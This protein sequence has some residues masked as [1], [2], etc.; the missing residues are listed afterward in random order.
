MTDKL[1]TS[2]DT[3]NA[4]VRTNRFALFRE[5]IAY[6][7][8]LIAMFLAF[9]TLARPTQV[10]VR[11]DDPDRP[12]YL[13][14]AGDVSVRDIDAKRFFHKIAKLLHAWDSASVMTQYQEA[15]Q[16]MTAEWALRFVNEVNATVDVPKSVHPDG[17]ASRLGSYIRAKVR[18]ETTVDWDALECRFSE[19]LWHCLGEISNTVQPLVGQPLDDP[20]L[21]KRYRITASF[22]EVRATPET[23]DSLMVAFWEAKEL[24]R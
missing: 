17:K 11:P 23:I 15:Q 13:V 22:A 1:P 2:F 16:L 5:L 7:V 12:S 9:T 20:A 8:A 24:K 10:I 4:L 19:E 21:T 6:G 3:Y 14:A 18:N